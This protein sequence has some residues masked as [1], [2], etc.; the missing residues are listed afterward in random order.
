MPPTSARC[1]GDR[2]SKDLS[3][4]QLK[5]LEDAT[6]SLKGRKLTVGELT[7]RLDRI[8]DPEIIS[9]LTSAGIN[10]VVLG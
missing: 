4:G 6:A 8:N 3:L 1:V 10:C 5:R 7:R 2:L 9:A